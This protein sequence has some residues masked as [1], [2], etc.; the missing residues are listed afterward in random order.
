MRIGVKVRDGFGRKEVFV[1]NLYVGSRRRKRVEV[2]TLFELGIVVG[3]GSR[4]THSERK[5]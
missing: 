3:G 5:G 2:S 1:V 4:D